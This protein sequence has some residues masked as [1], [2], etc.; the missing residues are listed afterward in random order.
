MAQIELKGGGF[1]VV[2]EDDLPRLAGLLWRKLRVGPGIYYAAAVGKAPTLLHRFITGAASGL[3][4]DHINGDPLD[5]RRSNLRVCTHAQ[6]LANRRKN[7]NSKNKFKGVGRSRHPNAW[8]ASIGSGRH[9]GRQYLGY[10]KSEEEAA[11]WYDI[12]AVLTY[13]E[14]ACLNFPHVFPELN[15]R[16]A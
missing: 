12:A 14:F 10:F 4:V 6:N 1:S 11:A 8:Y 9:K 15:Q 3:S 5:N 16:K 13:G 7:A 2:D